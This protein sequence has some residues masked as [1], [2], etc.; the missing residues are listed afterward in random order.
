[1]G[2]P[3]QRVINC[4]NPKLGI[5]TMNFAGALA[6]SGLQHEKNDMADRVVPK[7]L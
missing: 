7:F 6:I 1:M 2:Q 3:Y 4:K 5:M